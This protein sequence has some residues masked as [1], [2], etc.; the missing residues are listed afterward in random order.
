MSS[1]PGTRANKSSAWR[2]KFACAIAGGLWACRTQN[3]FWV[4]IPIAVAVFTLA[5]LLNVQSWQ[6][7]A[8]V[9]ATMVVFAA[10]LL[11][12]SIEQLVKAIH[13]EHDDRIGKS[14][15]TA[16]AGVLVTALGA[17][18]VG[19]LVLGPPLLKLLAG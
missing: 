12:T 10:E 3:S 18:A 19:L 2:N 17:V 1:E 13:P 8:L 7:V 11:N 16:A 4:H 9:I 14:L 15:D 5:A 6:W